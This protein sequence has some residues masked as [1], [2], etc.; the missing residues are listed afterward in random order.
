MCDNGTAVLLPRTSLARTFASA[1]AGLLQLQ[2]AQTW[3]GRAWPV[4][5]GTVVRGVTPQATID[6]RRHRDILAPLNVN[7]PGNTSALT[8]D[9]LWLINLP[10]NTGA[11]DRSQG[12]EQAQRDLAILGHVASFVW[13]LEADTAA[14]AP[15]PGLLQRRVRDC[16]AVVPCEEVAFLH[17]LFSALRDMAG[18]ELTG[19]LDSSGADTEVCPPLDTKLWHVRGCCRVLG[20]SQYVCNASTLQRTCFCRISARMLLL[21][22][23]DRSEMLTASA[24]AC[25]W[26]AC[27]TVVNTAKCTGSAHFISQTFSRAQMY[28]KETIAFNTLSLPGLQ[29]TNYTVTCKSLPRVSTMPR[30]DASVLTSSNAVS[31]ALALTGGKGLPG[32]GG[33][34]GVADAIWFWVLVA[35]VAGAF[36][37]STYSRSRTAVCACVCNDMSARRLSCA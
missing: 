24:A 20:C 9:K 2:T 37:R 23:L 7:V 35:A 21:D 32:D 26:S 14:L 4:P 12:T 27:L 1:C 16:V 13:L 36:G 22:L 19:A 10:T 8:L 17:D 33:D 15:R 25:A 5:A 11:L 3:D 18:S 6:F 31:L 30:A 29:A 28:D 34:G